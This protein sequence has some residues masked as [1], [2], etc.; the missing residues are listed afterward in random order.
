MKC[1]KCGAE[2]TGNANFCSYCGNRMEPDQKTDH[3][4]EQPDR[5]EGYGDSRE[6]HSENDGWVKVQIPKTEEPKAK[7]SSSESSK[8]RRY[9]AGEYTSENYRTNNYRT[10]SGSSRTEKP[11]K[12]REEA[13]TGKSFKMPEIPEIPGKSFFD[14]FQLSEKHIR[15]VVVI[16]VIVVV[17]NLLGRMLGGLML[18][19]TKVLSG[20]ET[21]FTQT[22]VEAPYGA[23][24]CIG[25]EYDAVEDAFKDAGFSRVRT[26]PIEDLK[27]EEGEHLY[28]I[29]EISIAGESSFVKGQKYDEEA[30]V[31][32]RYHAYEK[33][34]VI[35]HVDFISNLLF[36]KYD[37]KLALNGETEGTLSH[38]EDRD[39]E[40]SLDPGEYTVT[41]RS[42]ESSD[43]QGEIALTV[44]CDLE[45]AYQI[46][47]DSEKI[48]VETL[49]VDRMVEL[50]EGEVKLN[51]S[52]SEYRYKNYEEVTSA[53]SDLGFTN[54]E[55]EILYDIHYGITNEGE[56]DS[57][58]I[59]G[60]ADFTRGDIFRSDVPIVIVYHMKEENDPN[61]ES[62]TEKL[63]SEE[64]THS[65]ETSETGAQETSAKPM[66]YSTNTYEAAK[67]GKTGIF[68]YIKRGD[69][70]D[71]YYIIDFDGGYVYY[72]TEGNGENTC[73]RLK[74]DSGTLNDK[75]VITYHDG[76]DVW[77]YKLHFKYVDHPETL[78]MVDQNG[79]GWEYT[80]ANLNDALALRDSKKIKDY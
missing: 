39:F 77:S 64:Q 78:I 37:V 75:V 32:I 48:D 4:L 46:S 5:K 40:L 70:Y 29:E 80:T 35:L 47:C 25:M 66:F 68:S 30:T 7:G 24:E 76:N 45:A 72:F 6:S 52:S 79:F 1:S 41:F 17:F 10:K 23:E 74:I 14:K 65:E 18:V 55:Y 61:R 53:L 42:E 60:T 21:H 57:V 31:K 56:V 67:Q 9:T 49:Y 34:K 11:K 12:D 44:D 2:L 13:E 62:E 33:C 20:A 27:P 22:S 26:T 36:D 15:I 69:S 51:A 8:T 59:D 58:S 54:I 71:I 28:E 73:D 38:G 16:A 3:D 63:E 43:V 19:S 50:A